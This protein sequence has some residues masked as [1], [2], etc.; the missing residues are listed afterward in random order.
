MPACCLC[1]LR[2]ERPLYGDE[3]PSCSLVAIVATWRPDLELLT[4]THNGQHSPKVLLIAIS[5]H[6]LK[7]MTGEFLRILW[8]PKRI[9][10]CYSFL[11]N[12]VF[13]K[14]YIFCISFSTISS[15]ELPL[16][17]VAR[18]VAVVSPHVCSS[19]ASI[20]AAPGDI[21]TIDNFSKFFIN[22]SFVLVWHLSGQPLVI[23]FLPS[24]N[25]LI[26]D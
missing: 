5:H 10:R 15:V 21:F 14:C 1:Q 9:F 20:G 26:E 17:V 12:S 25:H 4:A 7:W 2:L 8:E 13:C 3:F 24:A 6:F 11:G 18:L 23:F 22:I 16:L 19:L